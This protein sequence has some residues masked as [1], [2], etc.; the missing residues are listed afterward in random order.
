[1]TTLTHPPEHRLNDG[2]ELPAVGLGTAP[3][4]DGPAQQLVESGLAAGYRLIDTGAI[5]GNEAGVGRG[6]AASG[7]PREDVRLLTKVRGRDQGAAATTAAAEESLRRLGLDYIDL[8]LIHWPMPHVDRYLETWEAMIVLRERG[9]VRTIGV[10]NFLPAHLERLRT[11][12]G[13][14]PAVNQIELHPGYAQPEVRAANEALG[15]RTLG[16]SPLGHGGDL[17]HDPT[18]VRI[19]DRRS[20]SP[21][22]VALRWQVE[23]G[24]VPLPR[25]A[26]PAQ[27]AAN[28]A[29]FD[30]R[31][32]ADDVAELAD[33]P[34]GRIGWDP[35]DR[36]EM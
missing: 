24:A 4:P 12:T 10:S 21:A 3:L 28:L 34:V 31:L 27:Q 25:T 20:V 16:Y 9:L 8:Y 1:M 29:I 32:D 14:I 7:V 30:F 2:S 19:A 11:A 15:V 22:Q 17:L 6:I 35:A 36:E 5:Y 33:L 23:L 18:I 26:K 13:V